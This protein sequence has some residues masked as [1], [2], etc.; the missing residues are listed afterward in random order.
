[1]SGI[2]GTDV[3]VQI[4]IL[5]NDVET[6][7]QKYADFFG[8]KKPESHMSDP[9]ETSLAEY[10]GKP[11]RARVKQAIFSFGQVDIELIQPDNEPSAWREALDAN[12]EGF[13]HI[14]FVVKDIN[15]KI[16]DLGAK[17]YTN[18]QTGRWSKKKEGG[19]SGIYSYIDTSG[20][21]KL[22]LELLERFN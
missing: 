17:G 18:I 15:G 9:I 13:H 2:L 22:I 21:L 16:A 10:R 6:A 7:A 5:V 4:G 12:G 20:E 1:M 8:V 3:V 11:T 14:A 19:N